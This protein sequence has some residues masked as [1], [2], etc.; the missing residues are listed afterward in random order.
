MQV[1][2]QYVKDKLH[3]KVRGRKCLIF[4]TNG[5]YTTEQFAAN[6]IANFDV[7]R[8]A[9]SD[10]AQWCRTDVQECRRID[11]KHLSLKA[12]REC[13][14]HL[15][16]A[17]VN[18]FLILEDYN[19]YILSATFMEEII[20]GIVNLRHKAVDVIVSYQ[21]LRAVEPRIWQNARWVKLFYMASSVDEIKNKVTNPTLF[22]I[23]QLIVNNRYLNGD[24]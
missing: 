3:N 9:I 6:G 15:L 20:G 22:R 4:D 2:S 14:E 1:I 5:E 10:V 7:K 13:V 18:C 12:K 17:T 11:G 16:S 24:N 23:A 19:T 8:I 21:S